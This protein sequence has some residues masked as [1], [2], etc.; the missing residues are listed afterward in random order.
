ML[1]CYFMMLAVKKITKWGNLNVDDVLLNVITGILYF[2]NSVF[3]TYWKYLIF[4][5]NIE[6]CTIWILLMTC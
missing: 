2:M 5:L 1:E 4:D 3:Q 6:N